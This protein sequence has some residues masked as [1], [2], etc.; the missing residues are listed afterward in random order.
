MSGAAEVV[1]RRPIFPCCCG[2]T[3]EAMASCSPYIPAVR[4]PSKKT[5]YIIIYDRRATFPQLSSRFLGRN[6]EH[7]ITLQVENKS[8]CL[9]KHYVV[10]GVQS[11]LRV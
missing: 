10:M 8:L 3:G 7:G 1:K 9:S 2:A 5:R 6:G 4:P 11:V